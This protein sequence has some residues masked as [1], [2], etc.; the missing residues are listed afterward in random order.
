M[1]NSEIKIIRKTSLRETVTRALRAAII[2]GE[3]VPGVIYSAPSLGARFGVSATP[4]REA[5]LDLVRENIVSVEPNKGFRVLEISDKDLDQMAQIRLLLEPP[6][7]RDVAAIIPK[8]DL[9]EL[10]DLAQQIVDCAEERDLVGYTDADREFHIRLLQYS[11]NSR[12]VDIVS[13]LRGHSRLSGLTQLAERGELGQSAQEHLEMVDLIE[14]GRAD[15]LE[16]LMKNHIAHVRGLW[17]SP[18]PA[19]LAATESA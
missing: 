13:D 8:E 17:A 12:L 14:E 3:M 15:D 10:R 19:T 4:V 9:A 2:A 16:E 18:E 5:M 1:T 7:V 6:V 11:G